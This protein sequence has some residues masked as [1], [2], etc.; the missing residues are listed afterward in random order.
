MTVYALAASLSPDARRLL[1]EM[2]PTDRY[3]WHASWF[4]CCGAEAVVLGELTRAGL[5][6]SVG[7]ATA[8]TWHGVA[9]RRALLDAEGLDDIAR[10]AALSMPD[11]WASPRGAAVRAVLRAMGGYN[12]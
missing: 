9:L 10:G 7:G 6:R 4:W 12:G 11:Q 1:C 8:I 5:A 2:G 3:S